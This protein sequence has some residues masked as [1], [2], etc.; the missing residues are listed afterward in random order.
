MNGRWSGSVLISGLNA[1]NASVVYYWGEAS[2]SAG[3]KPSFPEDNSVAHCEVIYQGKFEGAVPL[4]N[5]IPP[6]SL[7]GEGDKGGE[8]DKQSRHYAH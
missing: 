8:V 1:S 7:K 5:L 4:Q 2:L 6:L 3:L